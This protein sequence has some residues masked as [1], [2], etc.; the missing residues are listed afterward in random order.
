MEEF[1]GNYSKHKWVLHQGEN[2]KKKESL[3]EDEEKYKGEREEGVEDGNQSK[4]GTQRV[5]QT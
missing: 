4:V 3:K 1:G 2:I 5:Q